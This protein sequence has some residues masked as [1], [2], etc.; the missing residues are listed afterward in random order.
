M[1]LRCPSLSTTPVSM[2]TV[3]LLLQGHKYMIEGTI[4]RDS[5]PANESAWSYI[6]ML[7]NVEKLEDGL[8]SN[9]TTNAYVL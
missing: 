4:M 1:L 3:S 5:W 8:Y 6:N 7:K 2:V 9:T